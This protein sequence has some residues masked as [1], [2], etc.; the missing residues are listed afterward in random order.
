[1]NEKVFSFQ[2][3]LGTLA[4]IANTFNGGRKAADAET[5]NKAIDNDKVV[6]KTGS[7]DQHNAGKPVNGIY[8][9]RPA[10]PTRRSSPQPSL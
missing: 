4:M 2:A 3:R 1:M 5:S 8:E 9:S 7:M 6:P 10:S